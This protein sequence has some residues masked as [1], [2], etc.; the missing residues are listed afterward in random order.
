MCKRKSEIWG[1]YF[2]L[3]YA[4]KLQNWKR[5]KFFYH[6]VSVI[7][8]RPGWIPEGY[9]NSFQLIQTNKIIESKRWLSSLMWISMESGEY[10][11]LIGEMEAFTCAENKEIWYGNPSLVREGKQWVNEVPALPFTRPSLIHSNITLPSS[12]SLSHSTWFIIIASPNPYHT[13]FH[14]SFSPQSQP[15]DFKH[16]RFSAPCSFSCTRL[17]AQSIPVPSQKLDP[18][19]R[20]AHLT[21]SGPVTCS[22]PSNSNPHHLGHVFTHSP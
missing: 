18:F 10:V 14:P 4:H 13:S 1:K 3:Q 9:K 12:C 6:V 22:L 20:H 2:L 8:L 17:L 15:S 5:H 19:P 11:S 16:I 7:E 21:S